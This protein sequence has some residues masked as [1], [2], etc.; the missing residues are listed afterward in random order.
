MQA[1]CYKLSERTLLNITSNY[2]QSLDRLHFSGLTLVK[3]MMLLTFSLY[4]PQRITRQIL[5]ARTRYF[6]GVGGYVALLE[7]KNSQTITILTVRLQRE[8]DYR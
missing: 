5:H 7:I 4:L 1:V 6:F 8:V 2:H 3:V